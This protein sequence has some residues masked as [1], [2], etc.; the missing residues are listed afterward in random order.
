[1]MNRMA[2]ENPQLDPF[3]NRN[4]SNMKVIPPQDPASPSFTLSS[5]LECSSAVLAHCSL[6]FPGSSDPPTLA[7]QVSGTTAI[8]RR[9][10][11][12]TS[13]TRQQYEEL[14]A[15]F[16]QTMFPDRNLQEKLALKLNLPE[17]TVKNPVWF[18]NRRFKLKHQQQQQS[19]KQPNQILPFKKNVPTSP[20]TSPN[21]YAFSPVVSDFYSSL[22]PQPS[23]P[24]NWAWNSTFTE[25]PTSD[26]QMQDT[27]WERLVASV[28]ALYS[29]A[30]DI[31]QIIEL[32]SL[33]DENEISSYSFHC[34]YQYLSLTKYQ[35]GGQGSSL[36]TFA[37]LAVGLSPTQTWP[38]IRQGFE[39]YSLTD[40]LEFQKTSNMVDF[41]FL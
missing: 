16:S 13:F 7:S 23:D 38:S 15:L 24:S 19:A 18:R 32:Y 6:N 11:E 14:E 3:I 5:K 8:W 28:P 34:L 26:F 29:D 39:D 35:V 17:S 21:A 4:D 12:R 33:P 41:G 20:R 10:Q 40:S 27:Q 2:P 25:S 31:S 30:Y 9:H 22:P 36:S 37:G 1:M